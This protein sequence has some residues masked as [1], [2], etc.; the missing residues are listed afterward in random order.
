MSV[1]GRMQEDSVEQSGGDPAYGE[2]GALVDAGGYVMGLPPMDDEVGD[3]EGKIHEEKDVVEQDFDVVDLEGW[4]A[5]RQSCR[6]E[7]LP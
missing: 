3:G 1:D 2:D 6:G 4:A 5:A 7:C